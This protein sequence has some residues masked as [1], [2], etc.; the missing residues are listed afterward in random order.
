MYALSSSTDSNS[1]S[2]IYHCE[3]GE[4]WF[5]NPSELF[6]LI[7]GCWELEEAVNWRIQLE[8]RSAQLE[9][10]NSSIIAESAIS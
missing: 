10:S 5:N 9:T 1:G 4:K 8:T 6:I 7:T 3:P 2:A